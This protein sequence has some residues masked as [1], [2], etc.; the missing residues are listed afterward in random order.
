MSARIEPAARPYD[1]DMEETLEKLMPPGVEPLV[2]FRTLARNPRVF[3][4]FMAGGLLDKGTISMREREI[5]IDRACARCGGEYEWG[6]HIALFAERVGFGPAEVAATVAPGA[7]AECWNARER[8]I[9]RLVDQLHEANTVDDELWAALKGEF[10]DEQ[11]LELIVLTGFYHMVSFV[12][13]ATRLPLEDYA[14]RFPEAA[15]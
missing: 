2:L 10:S 6:V 15:A 12:V 4:R 7:D 14:A 9:V 1:K 13:N 8:L 3:R 11:L 5:A